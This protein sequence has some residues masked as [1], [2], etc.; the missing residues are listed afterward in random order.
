MPYPWL[1]RQTD[2]HRQL[3]WLMNSC[4]HFLYSLWARCFVCFQ[5]FWHWHMTSRC[6]CCNVDA[7]RPFAKI[8]FQH[9]WVNIWLPP[10]API[11]KVPCRN[12]MCRRHRQ[13]QKIALKNIYIL[14]EKCELDAS[15]TLR[16]KHGKIEMQTAIEFNSRIL[17]VLRESVLYRQRKPFALIHISYGE[18]LKSIQIPIGNQIHI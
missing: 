4:W 13:Q 17:I 3:I 12:H 11:P 7:V 16:E 1:D 8:V 2:R 9:S 18:L 10:I 15:S 14:H 6:C 5:F